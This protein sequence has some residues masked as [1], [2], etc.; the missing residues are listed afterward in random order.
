MYAIDYICK[1]DKCNH[2][3]ENQIFPNYDACPQEQKCPKCGGTM[4]KTWL[5]SPAI[6]VLEGQGIE[7]SKPSGYWRN[8]EAVKQDAIAKR[9]KDQRE[10][11]QYKDKRTM[12]KLANRKRNTGAETDD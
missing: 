1:D 4:I 2:I 12:E 10:K 9:L 8:A 6:E 7:S 11:I 5:Q 3:V